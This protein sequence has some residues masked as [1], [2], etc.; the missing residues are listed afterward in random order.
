MPNPAAP[1]ATTK[2]ISPRGSA[3]LAVIDFNDKVAAKAALQDRYTEGSPAIFLLANG[4]LKLGLSV[5]QPRDTS[6]GPRI[7]LIDKVGQR[8]S[9]SYVD[10]TELELCF[11][12]LLQAKRTVRAH[13]RYPCVTCACGATTSRTACYRMA[14]GGA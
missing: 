9:K 2:L 14:A 11:R 7:N 3:E 4:A 12:P 5:S 6:L 13:A 1:A 8:S 10:A